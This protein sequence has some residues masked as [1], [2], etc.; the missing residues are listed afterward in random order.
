MAAGAVRTISSADR[1]R[2][3]F[4]AKPAW[5]KR[6]PLRAAAHHLQAHAVVD[7][8]GGRHQRVRSMAGE[9]L[10]AT[11]AG[12]TVRGRSSRVGA[13]RASVPSGW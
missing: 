13:M 6:Q 3:G 9:S 8:L 10:S 5:Q 4:L 2:T 12:W 11:W 7:A 1:Q